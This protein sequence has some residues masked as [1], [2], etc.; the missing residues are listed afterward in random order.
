ML[1]VTDYFS[2]IDDKKTAKNA[3]QWLLKYGEKKMIAKRYQVSMVNISS[4]MISDMPSSPSFGNHVEDKM[5]K[6]IDECREAE[7]YMRITEQVI[8]GIEDDEL[9]QLLTLKYLKIGYNDVAVQSLLHMISSTFYNAETNA[10]IVFA[11]LFPPYIKQMVVS[12][13]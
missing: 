4:P 9:K 13:N 8:E 3:K 5:A 10:L 12:K 7:N 2:G 6:A 11:F 1:R